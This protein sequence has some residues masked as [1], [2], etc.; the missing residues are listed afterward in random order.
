M[1]SG[2][3]PAPT[4]RIAVPMAP[5]TSCG[6]GPHAAVSVTTTPPERSEPGACTLIL[7]YHIALDQARE[8]AKGEAKI[9]T[10][11]R[12]IG[13]AYEDKVARRAIRLQDLFNPQ[14]FADKLREVLDLHNFVLQYYLKA[15][16]VD[17]QRT[18]DETLALAPRLAPMVADVSSEL[19]RAAAVVA[20]PSLDEGFGFPALEAMACGVPVVAANRGALPEVV[21]EAGLLVNPEPEP[22]AAGLLRVLDD[23]AFSG[24]LSRDG[25]A[26]ASQ[27]TWERSAERLV[28]AYRRAA[29]A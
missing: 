15:K 9:G 23:H 8:M 24:R 18:Y 22:L 28:A 1:S 26:R 25:L 20:C 12:G 4:R 2:Y 3:S 27:F 11:G 6:N 19:Y 10:T 21:G 13:P 29:Q 5:P 16:P 14:R 7:P 17:F